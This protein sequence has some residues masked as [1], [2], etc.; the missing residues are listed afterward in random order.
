MI[1]IYRAKELKKDNYVIGS[2]IENSIDCPCIVD[3]DAEQYEIDKTTLSISFKDML[4]KDNKKIFAS[5]DYIG[6][7][8]GDILF[9]EKEYENYTAEFSTS[10]F[11]LYE[12]LDGKSIKNTIIRGIGSIRDFVVK[13]IQK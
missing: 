1:P 12:Y 2:Y 6:G 7:V 3:M 13:G 8:G 9:Y 11:M 10:G 5:L 4:D